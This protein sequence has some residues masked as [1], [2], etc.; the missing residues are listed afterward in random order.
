V[1]FKPSEI[2][3]DEAITIL[4]DGYG[5]KSATL[6]GREI[7]CGRMAIYGKAYRLGLC[8]KKKRGWM[9]ELRAP[10]A[11]RT[12][13]HAMI[14]P[15]VKTHVSIPPKEIPDDAWQPLRDRKPVPIYDLQPQHCR[16]PVTGGFCGCRKHDDAGPYCSTHRTIARVGMY[17][18]QNRGGA[19]LS[20]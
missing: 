18:L 6:L 2:W 3:T 1:P 15:R 12:E 8:G 10:R 17:G 5:K 16:W 4:R 11:P 20:P 14:R 13:T 7:G 9:P 19:N